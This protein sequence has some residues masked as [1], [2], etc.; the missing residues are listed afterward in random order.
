M[1][2]EDTVAETKPTINATMSIDRPR[3]VGLAGGG[4]GERLNDGGEEEM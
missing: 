3:F 2:T 1:R 4:G